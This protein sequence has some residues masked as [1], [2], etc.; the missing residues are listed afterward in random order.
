MGVGSSPTWLEDYEK[1]KYRLKT[2][3][4]IQP[5][6]FKSTKSDWGMFEFLKVL[7]GGDK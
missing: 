3:K 5:E 1:P 2:V 7:W 4:K 6:K